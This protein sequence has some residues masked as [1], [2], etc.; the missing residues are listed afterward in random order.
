MYVKKKKNQEN[1]EAT[2]RFFKRQC[3]N[4]RQRVRQGLYS[5][6]A[7]LQRISQLKSRHKFLFNY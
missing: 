2:S 1:R 7:I 6:I 5:R 4:F 3:R